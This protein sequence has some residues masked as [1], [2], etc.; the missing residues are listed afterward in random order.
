[1]TGREYKCLKATQV[2]SKD[3]VSGFQLMKPNDFTGR[4]FFS[5]R[6]SHSQ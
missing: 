6:C 3:Q 4:L 5:Y 2:A 1:M